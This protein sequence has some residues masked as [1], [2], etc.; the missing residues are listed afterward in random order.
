MKMKYISAFCF[1]VLLGCASLNAQQQTAPDSIPLKTDRYGIRLGV[2]LSKIARSLYDSDYKGLEI[3]GDYRLTK[4]F[5]LATELGNENKFTDD[6]QVDFRT[7]GTYFKVGFDYN[8]Y[9]NWLDMEN[10][11]TIGLRYG[12][13]SFSQELASYEI[14]NPHPYFG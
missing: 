6:D 13:S 5:W 11:I 2:D 3:V 9:E 14:Y 8:A 4:K 7:K 12:L 10:Q 1:S